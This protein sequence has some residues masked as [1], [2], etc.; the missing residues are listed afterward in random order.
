[1][2]TTTGASSQQTTSLSTKTHRKTV[3]Q[4]T[5][6]KIEAN[7]LKTEYAKQY[8]AAFKEATSVVASPNSNKTAISVCHRLNLKY[9]LNK[10]KGLAQS[11]V[12]N[13]LKDGL[14]GQSPKAK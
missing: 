14:E 12:Y 5:Q 11:T 8:K 9:N 3:K 1:M 10:K 7:R 4:A 2:T 6:D 13:A